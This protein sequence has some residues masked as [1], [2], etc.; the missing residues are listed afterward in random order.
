MEQRDSIAD[1]QGEYKVSGNLLSFGSTVKLDG[2]N[3]EI[4]SRVFM[5]SIKGHKKKHVIEEEEPLTKT[6]K[7]STWEE[8]NNIVM[9]WIMNSMQAHITPTIAY[10]TS[11][12]HMWEFLKQTYSHDKNMSK[13]LQVEEELLK[14]QQ[15]DTDLARYFA[16]VKSA[17]ERLKALHPPCQSCYKTH[18]EQH[19][20]AKFLAGLSPDFA[21]AKAQMLTGAEIP[22]L[23]EAYNRLSRPAVTLSPS[24]TNTPS[25]ALS[26]PGGRGQSLAISGSR[27]QT[28]NRGRGGRSSG[29]G[30][31]RFQCTFCG[32]LGQLEDRCWNKHGHP[33]IRGSE[34]SQI[35]SSSHIP[36]A[37]H[38]ED[39]HTESNAQ[40]VTVSM[41]KSEYEQFLAQK[42]N[43]PPWHLQ[44]WVILLFPPLCKTKI[45][46]LRTQRIIGGGHERGGVYFLSE[47]MDTAA[48][49]GTGSRSGP[50]SWGAGIETGLGTLGGCSPL[51][52]YN[53]T[54]VSHRSWRRAF[55]VDRSSWKLSSLNAVEVPASV[56]RL[57]PIRRLGIHAVASGSVQSP[58][59]PCCLGIRATSGSVSLPR[60]PG[61]RLG[62]CLLPPFAP[63][64]PS[65]LFLAP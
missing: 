20:V 30:C 56:F 55:F 34:S 35:K 5:M 57:Q 2:S 33:M 11:A 61:R 54:Y 23:A 29:G 1:T 14:L 6:G 9:S 25:S 8:N 24:S 43:L 12:K 16:S 4:W 17:Y 26:V 52:P 37:S 50:G 27:G 53:L 10:Y 28:F 41:S 49:S 64:A 22:D 42:L 38:V 39:D 63:V 19:M 36:K 13:V 65:L 7:Y 18:F 31:G 3:Y 62:F 40:Q 60:D 21:V 45:Q 32:R 58:R 48:T 59:D 15:G 46:D 51:P 44:L 47:A